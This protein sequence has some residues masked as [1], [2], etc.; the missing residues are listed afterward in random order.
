M[1]INWTALYAQT[2]KCYTSEEL[3]KIA[4]KMVEANTKAKLLAVAEQQLI[5]NKIALTAKDSAI[6]AKDSVITSMGSIVSL[7]EEIIAGKDHEI[8]ELRIANKK[9][10]RKNKWLK[11]K[12]AGTT[13][14]LAGALVYVAI[15]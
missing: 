6:F 7:K 12:W 15:K 5:Q 8:S 9:W 11:L 1:T 10:Q 4:N 13:I 3:L 14:G 2:G